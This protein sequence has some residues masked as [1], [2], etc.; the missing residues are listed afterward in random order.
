M[1]KT[2]SKNSQ[3]IVVTHNKLT[4]EAS[5]YLYG[6]TQQQKGISKIV[7]VNL[8]DIDKIILA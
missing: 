4:M 6:V 5:D 8:N 1:I 3:F 2:F 7:S